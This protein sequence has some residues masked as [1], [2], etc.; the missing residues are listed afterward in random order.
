M[1]GLRRKMGEGKGEDAPWG[2]CMELQINITPFLH[3]RRAKHSAASTQRRR[4][5]DCS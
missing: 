3:Q 1:V 4:G 5:E 2:V